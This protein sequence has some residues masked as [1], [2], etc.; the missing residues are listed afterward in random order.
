G[1]GRLCGGRRHTPGPESRGM[2]D[3][4]LAR[5]EAAAAQADRVVAAVRADQLGD[6]TP[7]TDWTVRDLINHLT[8]GNLMFAAI[9]SDGPRPDRGPDPPGQDHL[10]AFPA[11]VPP[12]A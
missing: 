3:D 8:T 12:L 2:T 1:G 10:A 4:P 5:F 11:P 7:C 6:P 9:V